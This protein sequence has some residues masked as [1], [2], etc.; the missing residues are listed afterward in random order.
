MCFVRT[1]VVDLFE[2][3]IYRHEYLKKFSILRKNK[4]CAWYFS[5]HIFGDYKK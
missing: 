4:R 2:K 1:K 3:L 5:K